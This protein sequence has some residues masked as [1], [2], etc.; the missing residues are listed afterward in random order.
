MWQ[1]GSILGSAGAP[2]IAS[3]FALNG[4]GGS[5]PASR[6]WVVEGKL[7]QDSCVTPG[8]FHHL[9]QPEVSTQETTQVVPP[10]PANTA[11][12]GTPL[13][14]LRGGFTMACNV[15]SFLNQEMS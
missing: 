8:R 6:P 12:T 7:D 15:L 2:G 1:F 10:L 5:Q 9:S 13:D 14:L 11:H 4:G 3:G